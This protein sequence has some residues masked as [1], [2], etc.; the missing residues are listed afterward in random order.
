MFLARFCLSYNKFRPWERS[1][2]RF[3]RRKRWNLISW[4]TK[5]TYENLKF[6]NGWKTTSHI[7]PQGFKTESTVRKTE[8]CNMELLHQQDSQYYLTQH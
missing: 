5:G 3:N 6:K 4:L 8:F 2:R 7:N 1:L